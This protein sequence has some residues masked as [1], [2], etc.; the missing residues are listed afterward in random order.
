MTWSAPPAVGI[1]L[2]TTYSVI[3]RLDER[4]LPVSLVNAE[5]DLLTPSAVLFDG[6]D[7]VVGKEAL[8]AFAGEAHRVA[9]FAKRDM[10]QR[11][12]HRP[13]DGQWYPPEVIQAFILK[14]LADDA[15]RA[16]GGFHQAV[17]TVPAYFDEVRRKATQDAGYMA[18]LEVIDI[19]NEPTAAAVAYGLQQGF[20]TAEGAAH[21]PMNVM[22]YDLGGGTFDVTVMRIEG[23]QFRTL[24]TDGDVELGGKDWD[25]RLIDLAAAECIRQCGGDPRQ[26]ANAA[27]RLWQECEDAKRTL[28]TR[29]R[30]AIQVLHAGHVLRVEVTREQFEEQTR[31]LLERTEFTARQALRQAGLDWGAVDRV[32]LVGGSTRMPMVADMLRRVSGRQP[33]TSISPDEAVAHGAALHAGLL[34]SRAQGRPARFSIR[35]VNSHSLGVVGTAASTQRRR[36]A[37]LIPRNT[38]LPVTARRVFKTQQPGQ[39]S[40]AVPIVEGESRDPDACVPLGT[41]VISNLPPNLPARTD[42]EVLFRYRTDGRLQVQVRIPSTNVQLQQEIQRENSLSQVQLD[43]WRLRIAGL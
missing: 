14:K 25:Q 19:I 42:V 7:V 1:D 27:A 20:L 6:S 2:G 5:G 10:G 12:Y 11:R 31:D 43:A 9:V 4:G 38:P 21:R 37:V 41:C 13:L 39:R 29:R 40:L 23:P 15:R 16:T 30:A 17:I 18:G 28:S 32:L 34:L 26:D 35:N 33:D 22:V 8:K 3:A 36:T 24:A